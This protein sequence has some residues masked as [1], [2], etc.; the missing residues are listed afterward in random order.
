[1]QIKARI[2]F[3][4]ETE[5]QAKVALKSLNPD[6]IGRINSNAKENRLIYDLNSDSLNSFLATVDDLL[7]CEIMVE[8]V[9]ELEK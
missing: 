4:Y 5:K 9:L 6:N 1:M 2:T 8:K 3:H 7:F